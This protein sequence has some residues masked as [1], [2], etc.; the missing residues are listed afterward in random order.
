MIIKKGR[1]E[2]KRGEGDGAG[3]GRNF[4]SGLSLIL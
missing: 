3:F 2:R 4:L 1:N